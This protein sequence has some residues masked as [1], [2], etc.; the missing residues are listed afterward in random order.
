ME[1][2]A[3]TV[4]T[5]ATGPNASNLAKAFIRETLLNQNPE[6]YIA[7]CLAIANAPAIDYA[8]IKAPFLL[9]AGQEDKSSSL[10]GCEKV[11]GLMQSA[12]KRMRCSGMLGIGIVSKRPSMLGR[13]LRIL[14]AGRIF[15][16]VQNKCIN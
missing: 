1:A 2:M 16:S 13:L 14:W 8:A 11:Y 10:E 5:A 6:A 9:I 7:L 3:N 12:S 15:R 4:P